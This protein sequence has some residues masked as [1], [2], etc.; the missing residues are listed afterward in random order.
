M[1][2]NE[3]SKKN[4]AYF[5]RVSAAV[6]RD[7]INEMTRSQLKSGGC[8]FSLVEFSLELKKAMR[9]VENTKPDL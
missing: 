4:S 9:D 3:K 1:S 7:I 5:H 8:L 6:V 2:C